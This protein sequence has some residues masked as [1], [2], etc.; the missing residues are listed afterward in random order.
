MVK[1]SVSLIKKWRDKGQFL[2]KNPYTSFLIN[3]KK[4]II[5]SQKMN[6]YT[7]KEYV[8]IIYK[9][10][11][12]R[13]LNLENPRLFNEKLQWL[14]IY[15]RDERMVICADKYAVREYV[16][17]K[18]YGGLLNT[19]YGVYENPSD[20]DF[21][22]LPDKFVLK[23]THGSGWNIICKDKNTYDWLGW[24]L[25][26]KSWLKQNLYYYGRE[27]VYKDIKPQIICE[28]YIEGIENQNLMDYKFFCFNG[29]PKLIQIDIDRFI[30]HKRD[31]YDTE[32]KRLPFMYNF[33]NSANKA[34]ESPANL[35]KMLKIAE[36]LSIGYP[37]ARVDLY[38]VGTTIIFGEITFFPES[39]FGKFKPAEYD[40][41]LGNFLQLPEKNFNI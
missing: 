38:N 39:G 23:A 16:K 10:S 26:M 11:F 12:S 3:E 29:K 15:Y 35:P 19:L 20:I 8:S 1:K 33:Q 6:R 40:F 2:K 13:E 37:F 9:N 32:W 31:M 41:K 34:I 27:W 18:G 30:K 4:R 25:V 21:K 36:A 7:D 14:K 17:E 5:F 28:K 22:K 24:K